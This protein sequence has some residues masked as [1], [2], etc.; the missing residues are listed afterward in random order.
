ML[1]IVATLVL[2]TLMI[3]VSVRGLNRI[4]IREGRPTIFQRMLADIRKDVHSLDNITT[5]QAEQYALEI[6]TFVVRFVCRD[7]TLTVLSH[8]CFAPTREQFGEIIE[9]AFLVAGIWCP[10]EATAAQQTQVA[11]LIM[12]DTRVST[13]LLHYCLENSR[14]IPGLRGKLL[15]PTVFESDVVRDNTNL[16]PSAA[17]MTWLRLTH[18]ALVCTN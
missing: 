4:Y 14:V 2:V 9:D 7:T 1:I 15:D 12:R 10:T 13:A 18:E 11:G 16:V 5:A 3:S 6:T 8:P 17:A